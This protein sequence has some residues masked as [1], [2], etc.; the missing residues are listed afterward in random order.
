MP[1]ISKDMF[2]PHITLLCSFVAYLSWFL[3][4]VSRLV[5]SLFVY[6]TAMPKHNPMLIA[7]LHPA[8]STMYRHL[9]GRKLHWHKTFLLRCWH[10][11][12]LM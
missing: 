9:P 5:Q 10:K 6:N 11:P 8:T 7:V 4:A 2:V 12:T 1:G 3:A